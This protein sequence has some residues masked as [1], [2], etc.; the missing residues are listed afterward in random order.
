[1]TIVNPTLQTYLTLNSVE[2]KLIAYPVMPVSGN[3]SDIY[4]ADV[5]FEYTINYD[6]LA[7]IC[8]QKIFMRT[9]LVTAGNEGSDSVSYQDKNPIEYTFPF[10]SSQ[11]IVLTSSILQYRHVAGI[12]NQLAPL[13]F[14]PNNHIFGVADGNDIM[15]NA[16]NGPNSYT[17]LGQW[18]HNLTIN[19]SST[20]LRIPPRVIG[21]AQDNPVRLTI[22]PD[23]QK[24]PYGQYFALL[25]S[26][27]LQNL[28]G[29]AVSPS[30]A[31]LFG[32]LNGIYHPNEPMEV[33]G[34][35][36]DPIPAGENGPCIL[37]LVLDINGGKAQWT[38]N[39]I[40]DIQITY[41]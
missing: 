21:N 14:K 36:K 41:T 8:G 34:P 5:K 35:F 37:Y 29:D 22:V 13:A 27:K 33:A 24:D 7:D 6:Q 2:V 23:Y 39:E 16:T 28:T 19:T 26:F 15:V 40:N 25:F 38:L 12:N 4:A 31:Q 10:G 17:M 3:L 1:M 20:G 30:A 32:T 9:R 11:T 18:I